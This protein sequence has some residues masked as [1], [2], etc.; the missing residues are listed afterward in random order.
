MWKI[1][2]IICIPLV[3]PMGIMEEQCEIYYE[4]DKRTFAT[5]VECDKALGIRAEEMVNG[6]VYLQVPFNHMTF[7]CE[8]EKD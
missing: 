2:A 3:N 5:E 1:F 6:F 7:G 4:T 8:I